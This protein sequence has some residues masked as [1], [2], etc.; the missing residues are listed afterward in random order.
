MT[1]QRSPHDKV[2]PYVML[3]KELLQDPD[4]SWAAKGLLSYLLSLPNDWKI[5]V[6][7]L[8]KIYGGK[9]GGEKAIYSLLHELIDVG[10]CERVR[11]QNEKGHFISTDYHITEFKKSLPLSSQRDAVEG[12]AFERDVVEGDTTNTQCIQNNK[13]IVCSVGAPPK[14]G[15]RSCEKTLCSGEKKEIKFDDVITQSIMQN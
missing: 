13:T 5:Q 14:E 15:V 3:N 7:H 4:L 10:Y 8:S 9:G 12:D 11:I 6:S 1:I 2:N